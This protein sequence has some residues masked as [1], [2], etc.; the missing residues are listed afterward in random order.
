MSLKTIGL[1]VAAISFNVS[2]QSSYMA[3]LGG[4]GEPKTSTTIFDNDVNSVTKFAVSNSQ[5]KT[6][7]SFNG[8]HSKTEQ[9]IRDNMGGFNST[10]QTFTA[11][12]FENIIKNYETKILAGE[13]KQGDQLMLHINTHGA[14]RSD[15]VEK[16]HVVST[17][18]GTLENYDTLGGKTVSL[19]RLKRLTELAEQRGIKLAIIDLSCH[20]GNTLNLA[21]KNTCVISGTG[22][23][24]Y[25][26]G[27][28]GSTFTGKFNEKLSKGKSLE[29]VFLEARS[30][31][32]DMSFPMISSPQGQDI[33]KRIYDGITPYLYNYDPKHDKLTPFLEKEFATGEYCHAEEIHQKLITEVESLMSVSNKAGTKEAVDNFKKT[34]NDYYTYLSNLRKDMKDAGFSSLEEKQEFC[35]AIPKEFVKKLKETK[36]CMTY[37]NKQL[38]TLNFDNIITSFTS[39]AAKAQLPEDRAKYMAMVEF[40]EKAKIAKAKLIADNPNFANV[41]KFWESYPDRQSKT[42]ELGFKVARAQQKVYDLLYRNSPATGPNPC[43]D[44]IL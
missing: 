12:S 7:L 17:A 22:P 4:G 30:D 33:Q 21:N 5:W 40:L 35:G 31:F 39:S 1:L 38:L 13:I 23:N 20:S 41:E 19:D 9:I 18:E 26:Y 11:Q 36:E 2:A 16:T 29:A 15:A 32:Y 34:A 43:R 10:T 28:G 8:G 3:I 24:H 27:G 42:N 14:T 44:F 37:T 25:G 6:T